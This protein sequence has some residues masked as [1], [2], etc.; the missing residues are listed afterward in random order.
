MLKQQRIIYFFQ[1]F[2]H[3]PP[4]TYNINTNKIFY[5]LMPAL[6][7]TV[8]GRHVVCVGSTPGP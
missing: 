8:R 4:K 6:G 2:L 5:E 7:N 1:K 3:W